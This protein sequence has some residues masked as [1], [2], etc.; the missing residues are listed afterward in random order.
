[1]KP[2]VDEKEQQAVPEYVIEGSSTQHKSQA[3]DCSPS[4]GVTNEVPVLTR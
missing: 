4:Q 2:S 3:A 1:M